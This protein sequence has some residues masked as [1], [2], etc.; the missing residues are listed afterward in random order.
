[1]NGEE[2]SAALSGG[3]VGKEKESQI[4]KIALQLAELEPA[5]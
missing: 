5:L 2:G 1:V 4:R 3:R